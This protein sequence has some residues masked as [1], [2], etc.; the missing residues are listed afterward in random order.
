MTKRNVVAVLKLRYCLILLLLPF[1]CLALLVV[2]LVYTKGEYIHMDILK[3]INKNTKNID[4]SNDDF[5]YI[6][7]NGSSHVPTYPI[8]LFTIWFKMDI[9]NKAHHTYPQYYVWMKV[10]LKYL[11]TP[12]VIYTND[13]AA[14]ETFRSASDFCAIIFNKSLSDLFIYKKYFKSYQ[15]QFKQFGRD[16]ASAEIYTLWNAKPYLLSKISML[17]PFNSNYFF[18][19]DIGVWR[20][21]YRANLVINLQNGWWPSLNVV[22]SVF[23]SSNNSNCHGKEHCLLLSK[24][25]RIKDKYKK[26]CSIW[27]SLS[28]Q[29][30]FF[31]GNAKSVQWFA[32]KYY[33]LLDRFIDNNIY[34]GREEYV[35]AT[36]WLMESSQFLILKAYTSGGSKCPWWQWMY[37]QNFFSNYTKWK[38][39]CEQ[40]QNAAV[41][42]GNYLNKTFKNDFAPCHSSLFPNTDN[43]LL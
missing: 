18:F 6:Y 37:F 31:G 33:K 13:A 8:T 5:Q 42:D 7:H 29:A 28:I 16:E 30:G 24:I 36:L 4:A 15:K 14:F 1:A 21:N 20:N 27:H 22:E 35:F 10:W 32:N 17:N 11:R 12:I 40:I 39:Q 41:V 23:D 3:M 9:E 38:P 2:N 25:G 26:N 34:A 43:E 19:C